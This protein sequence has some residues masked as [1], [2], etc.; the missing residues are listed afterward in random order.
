M[1]TAFYVPLAGLVLV[2]VGLVIPS[3][4]AGLVSE[5]AFTYTKVGLIGYFFAAQFDLTRR[6]MNAIDQSFLP[7]FAQLLASAFHIV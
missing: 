2:L 4:Q 3:L 6:F 7:I 5:Y 1:L